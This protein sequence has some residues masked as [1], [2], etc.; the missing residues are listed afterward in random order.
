MFAVRQYCA[1]LDGN[2]KA[3]VVCRAEEGRSLRHSG[4]VAERR[5]AC[6]KE[7]MQNVSRLQK[8]SR[9]KNDVCK[10]KKSGV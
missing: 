5:Q 2:G 7:Y 3:K 9:T 1:K 8:Q 6:K 4:Q 10:A